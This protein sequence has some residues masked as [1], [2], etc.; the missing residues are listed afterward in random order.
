MSG[1]PY[2]WGKAP[3]RT[4]MPLHL[5]PQKDLDVW[6]AATAT[7][8]PFADQGGERANMRPHSNRRLQSSYGRWLTFLEGSGDLTQSP[9]PARRIR[10]DSVEQFVRKLQAL[11][12]MP[13]TIALRLTDLLLMARIFEPTA[14]WSF[15]AR[16]ADR[17]R[18]MECRGKDKRLYLRG[19]D[20]LFELG[21]KLMESAGQQSSS[22]R[23]ASRFRDGLMIALLALV[24]LRRKNFVQLRIGTELKKLDGRWAVEIPGHMTKTHAPLDFDWPEALADSLETYLEVHRPVLTARCYRWLTRAEDHLWVAQ[25]GS[26]LTQMAFYDNV[27]KRTKA[28][29]GS[30]INPHAFRDAAATTLAIH[31]P[32]HVR[33][34]APVLGHRSLSTTEKFYNQ[35]KSLDAHRRYTDALSR[36]RHSSRRSGP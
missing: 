27:R 26:A 9:W 29:F 16:L 2:G 15:I 35:S 24:P 14:D 25:S 30:A 21:Q 13:S 12:N 6:K 33:V 7:V 31:D 36:L 8:D 19:S 17:I 18:A 34:A 3:E 11:G 28:A 23:A 20:E 10:K 32:E 1:G 5:W 4:S 22:A